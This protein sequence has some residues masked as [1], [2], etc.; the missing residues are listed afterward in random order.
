MGTIEQSQLAE[1]I[2]S[3]TVENL[4][5]IAGEE[6]RT[7]LGLESRRIGG[8]IGVRM[9]SAPDF[10]YLTRVFA[11][12]I[13]APFDQSALDESVDFLREAGGSVLA[14][15]LAPQVETPEALA[16]LEL[17]GFTRGGS[18]SK[19]MRPVGEAPEM[20]TDLRIEQV[21][22]DQAMELAQVE[23]TGMKMPDF[24]LPWV[25]KQVSAPGWSA[26]GAF[27]GDEMVACGL[28]FLR[29]GVAQLSGAATLP[30]HRGQGAQSALMK[31]R[32]EEAGR[33]GAK[34][35]CAETGSETLENPNAS[36]HNMYRNGLELLYER[37]NWLLRLPETTA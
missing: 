15:Q 4:I 36:L 7:T 30:S 2:E 18:W 11:L 12:G 16:L 1:R 20:R 21:G 37:R 19:M 28:L 10:L 34:W 17:R 26:W 6:L 33:L 35:V 23:I 24:M 22:A 9:T 8:G 25:A 5:S 14:L 27:D 13:D 31:V 32:I 3:Q 29:D